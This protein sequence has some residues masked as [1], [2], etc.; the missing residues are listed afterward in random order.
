MVVNT[1]SYSVQFKLT[2]VDPHW[3]MSEE[4]PTAP[5]ID[6]GEYWEGARY[7][8]DPKK[9]QKAAKIFFKLPEVA[10][11]PGTLTFYYGKSAGW[12]ILHLYASRDGTNYKE[13]WKSPA[14]GAV[15]KQKVTVNVPQGY[16]YLYFMFHDGMTAWEKL[17]LWKSMTVTTENPPQTQKP[18]LSRPPGFYDLGTF[19]PPAKPGETYTIQVTKNVV[20]STQ[21]EATKSTP[22]VADA[23][24]KKKDTAQTEK[25]EIKATKEVKDT[26]ERQLDYVPIVILGLGVVLALLMK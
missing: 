4:D 24:G 10:N 12:N 14:W 8:T 26:G 22:Q 17:K 1:Q 23:E 6:R 2:P 20:N 13:I 7:F 5:L 11:S 16:Q 25:K 3:V 19:R 9:P 15:A 21:L 18:D